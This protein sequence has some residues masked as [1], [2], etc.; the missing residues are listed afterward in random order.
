MKGQGR[1]AEVVPKT[2]EQQ[3]EE[4]AARIVAIE[5]AVLVVSRAMQRIA[6]SRVSKKMLVALIHD[7]SRLPKGQIELVL[8]NLSQLEKTWLKPKGGK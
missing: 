5:D 7:E 3:A 4:D 8:N 1:M 2:A 6:Q